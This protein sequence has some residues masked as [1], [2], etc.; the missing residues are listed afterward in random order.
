MST[1]STPFD[2]WLEEHVDELH[3]AE[4]EQIKNSPV[5]PRQPPSNFWWAQRAGAKAIL[6]ADDFDRFISLDPGDL[7]PDDI[8]KV[9]LEAQVVRGFMPSRWPSM[10]SEAEELAVLGDLALRSGLGSL[11]EGL[12]AKIRAVEEEAYR[13]ATENENLRREMARVENP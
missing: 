9:L 8:F 4:L 13:V 2:A 3:P 7:I 10:P 5:R 6:S 1:E 12:L 11:W